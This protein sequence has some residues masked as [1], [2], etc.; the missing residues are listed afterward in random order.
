[1]VCPFQ[2]RSKIAGYLG[3]T[4]IDMENQPLSPSELIM[5]YIINYIHIIHNN[6]HMNHI[7]DG[8]YKSYN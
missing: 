3:S 7:V 1:V 8:D 2:E 5:G 4:N 6:I